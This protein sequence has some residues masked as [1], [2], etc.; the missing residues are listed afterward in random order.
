MPL[1]YHQSHGVR[2]EASAVQS[3]T[4]GFGCSAGY[5][6]GL[7]KGS[8]NTLI[9]ST[10]FTYELLVV[11]LLNYDISDVD[12][13]VDIGIYDGS[14]T[15]FI[16]APDLHLPF[17][18]PNDQESVVHIP[19]PLHIPKGSLLAARALSSAGTN[20]IVDV[21]IQGF[22]SNYMGVPGFSRCVT[23]FTPD[24]TCQGVSCDVSAA[25]TRTR[26][27]IISSSSAR[28]GAIFAVIGPDYDA[29]GT[30]NKL[31]IDIETG[32]SGS[33][34]ILAPNLY[35]VHAQY[36]YKVFPQVTPLYP[37]DVPAGERFSVN[38]QSSLK[39]DPGSHMDFSL[40]GLVP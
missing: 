39:S 31:C 23:L 40:Y 2:C 5:S 37:C 22:S 24:S 6:G 17:S 30:M 18:Y 14:S 15:Y 19:L 25:N 8:W 7:I 12:F 35:G 4:R 32:G 3:G 21:T 13:L 11:E 9:A 33:E 28:V 1:Q 20:T 27:Q 26:V 38:Y 34:R 10:T 16:I 29:S 36:Q